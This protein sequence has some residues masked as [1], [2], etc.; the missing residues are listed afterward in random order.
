MKGIEYT[1]LTSVDGPI[2]AVKRSE[3]SSY[4]EVVYVRDKNGEKKTG[5]IIDLNE[6][7]AIVQILE[8]QLVLT[9]KIQ[10]WNSLKSQWNC[11]LEKGFLDAFSTDLASL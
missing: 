3:N 11:V 5:R 8:A 2:V 6:K 7:T 10:L 4:D 9:W 1:G